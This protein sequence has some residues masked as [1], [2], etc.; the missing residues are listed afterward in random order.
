MNK[1]KFTNFMLLVK[2]FDRIFIRYK[3]NKGKSDA[4]TILE[5]YL[6]FSTKLS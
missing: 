3:Y 5:K 2:I 1:A 6:E 4:F